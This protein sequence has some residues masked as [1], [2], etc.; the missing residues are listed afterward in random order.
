M[1]PLLTITFIFF[2]TSLLSQALIPDA[3]V[4]KRAYKKLAADTNNNKLIKSY[5]DAFP[6]NSK[7]FLD[8][9]LSKNLDQLDNESN[10]YLDLFERCAVKYPEKVLSKCVKIGKNLT[11]DADVVGQLQQISI[12]LSIKYLNN[13]I[14]SYNTLNSKEQNSLINFYA[15]VEN[16]DAYPEFQE[17]IDKLNSLGQTGISNKLKKARAKRK[18]SDDH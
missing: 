3:V 2:F 18:R 7:T 13:F 9:F 12:E 5:I 6:S 14:D 11:W 1:K 17:L 4:V 8:L 16:Y 10:K 15:D